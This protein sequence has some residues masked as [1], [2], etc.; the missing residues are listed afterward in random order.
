MQS[1]RPRCFLMPPGPV[2][3]EILG[4]LQNLQKE[5]FWARGVGIPQS[6]A[7]Q[8]T[9]IPV[10]PGNEGTRVRSLPTLGL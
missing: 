9:M 6:Q 1:R 8:G 5:H 10:V 3:G 7:P 4:S 2:P